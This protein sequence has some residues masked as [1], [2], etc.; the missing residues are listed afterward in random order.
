[1]SGGNGQEY[2]TYGAAKEAVGSA[3]EKVRDVAPDAYDAGV[4]AARYVGD[5]AAEHPFSMLAGAAALALCGWLMAKSG[6]TRPNWQKQAGDWQRQAR[7]L[8]ERGYG[9][10]RSAVPEVSKAADQAGEYVAQ[11]VRENPISG[12]LIAAAVGGLLT[13]LLQP[14]P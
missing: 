5:T 12:L 10:V 11:T 2:S 3:A 9:Q 7:N 13:Y 1:M 4:R 14:R 6:D 8:Q